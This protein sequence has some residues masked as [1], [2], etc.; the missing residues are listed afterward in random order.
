MITLKQLA[1]E[2][3]VSISTVSKALR[4]SP[5]ISSETIEKVKFLANKYDYRPNKIALSLKSNRTLTIG[6]IIPDIL[7][8]FYSKVL[9]GIHDSADKHGYDVITINTKE[10]LLKEIDSLRILSTGTVDGV[11]IAMSE[12][13]LNKNDYS[14]IKEFTMKETPIVM[15]D[16]VT[17]KINCDKVIIDDF[18]AIYNEVKSLKDL[19]RKK[20][21]FITTINDLNVGKYRANGFRKATFDFYGKFNK[22]LILRIPKNHDKHIEIEKFIKKNKPDAL[23]SADIICGVIS[24]NIARNLNIEVPKE[25]SVVGFGDKTISEYSSPKLTTIY[26]HGTEIG[27]RSVELLV[28]RMNSKWFGLNKNLNSYSTDIIPTL[29]IGGESK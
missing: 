23:I 6:V 16:R 10:S 20:I 1:K 28:D 11:I 27:N 2:L 15:F 5:E 22:N 14:H 18:D 4:D 19:G 29:T 7:N 24:I 13:T 25:L 3:K 17:D 26:Q 21:G 9:N 12:E 8:R